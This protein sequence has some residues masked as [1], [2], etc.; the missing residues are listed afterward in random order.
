[1]G[2]H[3]DKR[4]AERP[5]QPEHRTRRLGGDDVGVAGRRSKGEVFHHD[6][7]RLHALNALK[8]GGVEG[9]YSLAPLTRARG[10]EGDCFG[11]AGVC[12]NGAV[13]P[14]SVVSDDGNSG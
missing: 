1:M 11:S 9:G 14:A 10:F 13:F 2:S 5:D 4:N 12:M 8:D 3:N 6:D 7:V